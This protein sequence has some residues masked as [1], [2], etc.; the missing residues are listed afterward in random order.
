MA[1]QRKSV[2]LAAQ[3]CS[4]N[5]HRLRS[6]PRTLATEPL[7]PRT[8][9]SVDLSDGFYSPLPNVVEFQA[10]ATPT[11]SN[12]SA[13][14][15]AAVKKV[16]V[17]DDAPNAPTASAPLFTV[18]SN[19]LGSRAGKLEVKG[20]RDAFRFSLSV[21]GRYQFDQIG[22][23]LTDS[24][25]R[26]YNS[27]GVMIGAADNG[28]GKLNSRIVRDLEAGSYYLVAGSKGDKLVGN[29]TLRVSRLALPNVAPTVS[30]A[31]AT[32]DPVVA[33]TSTVL[34]VLGADDGGEANLRYTWAA[35]TVPVGATAPTY[36][37]NG[38][39]AAKNAT[40]TF[41]AAGNYRLSVAIADAAGLTVTSYVDVNVDQTLT[42]V[43]VTPGNAS[44]LSDGTKQFAAAAR[45]QFNRS[46]GVQPEFVWSSTIGAIN[47]SGL[48]TA[49]SETGSGQVIATA[50]LFTGSANINVTTF[51]SPLSDFELSSLFGTLFVDQS[52]DRSDM[53]QLLRAAGSDNGVVDAVELADLRYLV[54]N[55]VTYAIPSYVAHLAGDVVNGNLANATYLGQTL[56]NLAAGGTAT[57]L[58]MLVDKWFLGADHPVSSYAY[59]RFSGSLIV[60]GP[61]YDDSD[62][63]YLGDC[64]FIA[65][66]DAIAKSSPSAIQNMFADNGDETWT[67][68]FFV[69]GVA[70]YVSVDRY[71]PSSYSTS[72]YASVGGTYTNSGNELWM[73]LAEKAYAQ[74]NQTGNSGRNGTNTYSAIE[75][76]W[77]Q[78]VNQQ[79]LGTA[80][81]TYWG[82]YDSDKQYLVAALG[83]NKAVTYGTNSNPGNG[84]VGPHAY[85]VVSYNPGND[86]FQLYNPWGS[87][88]PGALTYAQLRASGQCF[89]VANASGT[90]PLSLLNGLR[91]LTTMEQDSDAHIIDRFAQLEMRSSPFSSER[92]APQAPDAVW[93]G[94]DEMEIGWSR[95]EGVDDNLARSVRDVACVEDSLF[96]RFD[97][98]GELL[99]S[100]VAS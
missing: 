59:Q 7:E 11:I 33:T 41:S 26:L 76:G 16:T 65:A 20:D 82:L 83:A 37:A 92:S 3:S 68:R 22:S 97:E 14:A 56:G 2:G 66:M 95:I 52:I 96:A 88:H 31:A 79:V 36:S 85:M 10:V 13:T 42:S 29:Y 94:T 70:D 39:N 38:N 73:A 55:A 6:A 45:D 64:Y 67:V 18:A 63:G 84:M 62:Q 4:R 91:A 46:M 1:Q 72:I 80:S 30:I 40:V 34:S 81:Q 12:L 48:F 99:E 90:L 8:L 28:A 5:R 75:G 69:N 100:A 78:T 9:C 89:V 53:I 98:L 58:N 47:S 57:Q 17:K 32:A 25:L 43:V 71:L 86:T 44:V 35:T 50:G 60:N 24:Y 77:M 19:G 74:W 87:T 61:A 49:S 51:V 15:L 23:S 54:S 93:S 27:Q 21:G